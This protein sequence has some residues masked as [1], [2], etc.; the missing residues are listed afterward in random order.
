MVSKN[1]LPRFRLKN[2]QWQVNFFVA[3][4]HGNCYSECSRCIAHNVCHAGFRR[5]FNQI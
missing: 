5:K 1:G 2:I 4:K 3:E